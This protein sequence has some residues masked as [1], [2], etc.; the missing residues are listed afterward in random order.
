MSTLIGLQAALAADITLSGI[1]IDPRDD[2]VANAF[3][4]VRLPDQSEQFV[5]T[6]QNGQFTLEFWYEE[7]KAGISIEY[8]DGNRTLTR[9]IG[10]DD[11]EKEKPQIIRLEM[12]KDNQNK[13]RMFY[14]DLE[15]LDASILGNGR[16][17]YNIQQHFDRDANKFNL[18]STSPM[19]KL[20]E[21]L[22]KFG[23]ND[24]DWYDDGQ[25]STVASR[26]DRPLDSQ[27][28]Y[29][30]R[31]YGVY[32]DEDVRDSMDVQSLDFRRVLGSSDGRNLSLFVPDIT[33]AQSI[34][35]GVLP[36]NYQTSIPK[37]E[38]TQQIYLE[39]QDGAILAP[40]PELSRYLTKDD[41]VSYYSQT[42]GRWPG[43]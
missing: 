19:R 4:L 1:V 29:L 40:F 24:I 27:F 32:V 8:K 7:A 5:V 25:G 13:L 36:P 31:S 9:D 14:I 18:I 6:D 41:V 35:R 30:L 22:T 23:K 2:P 38:C 12:A 20:E 21:I 26:N 16:I 15:G 10:F 42:R 43:R 28:D 11:L 39:D 17:P 34:V 3:L 37:S 33:A